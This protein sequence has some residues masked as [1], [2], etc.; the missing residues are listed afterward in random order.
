MQ[1]CPIRL[2]TRPDPR[3]AAQGREGKE[4]RR[5]GGKRVNCQ[6]N[7][8]LARFLPTQICTLLKFLPPIIASEWENVVVVADFEHPITRRHLD[9]PF[10]FRAWNPQIKS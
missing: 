2:A 10:P 4:E 8:S 5:K 1:R 7:T 3:S 9:P 6:S